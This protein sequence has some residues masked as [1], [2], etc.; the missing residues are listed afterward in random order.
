MQVA[1]YINALLTEC[2][3]YTFANRQPYLLINLKEEIKYATDEDTYLTLRER[4]HGITNYNK[5]NEIFFILIEHNFF[6]CIDYLFSRNIYTWDFRY[7]STSGNKWLKI[8]KLRARNGVCNIFD[9][10]FITDYK[11]CIKYIKLLMK[12]GHKL[13]DIIKYHNQTNVTKEAIAHYLFM[14][15]K[16]MAWLLGVI[17]L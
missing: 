1:Y 13:H 9:I 11:I 12:H 17:T 5:T 7:S 2:T 16:R 10:Q 3:K 4:L 15:S 14:Q 8:M 6:K